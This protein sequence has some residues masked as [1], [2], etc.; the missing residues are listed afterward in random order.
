MF[1]EMGGRG[2]GG[3]VVR[4]LGVGERERRFVILI[5]IATGRQIEGLDAV[6]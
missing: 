3:G 5:D 6:R 1:M 2:R 4:R